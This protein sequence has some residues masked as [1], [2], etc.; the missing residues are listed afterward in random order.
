MATKRESSPLLPLQDKQRINLIEFGD[1][2]QGFDEDLRIAPK[3]Q[4]L[5]LH[6]LQEKQTEN[7]IKVG[8]ETQGFYEDGSGFH[9]DGSFISFI[10]KS[11]GPPQLIFC[12]FVYALSFGSIIGV[13]P[14]VMTDRYARLN[15]G[16]DGEDCSYYIGD[17]KPFECRQ[18]SQDAQDL[19]ATTSLISNML[20]FFSSSLLGSLG[21]T[22]GRKGILIAGVLLGMASPLALMMIQLKPRLSPAWYYY[23]GCL[24]GLVNWL[25]VAISALSDVVPPKWR[26]PCFGLML[27]GFSSG[28]AISPTLSLTM[29]HTSISIF[30]FSILVG[31][32]FFTIFVVPETLPKEVAEEARRMRIEKIN[33]E[34]MQCRN[35]FAQALLRPMKELSILNRSNLFRLLSVLAFFSSVISA[36][37]QNLL[38][39]Y[40]EDRYDFNDK[41]V[42]LLFL[43]IGG[44]G[45]AVQGFVLKPLNDRM[46]EKNLIILS[47]SVGIFVNIL[48][49]VA[50]SKKVIFLAVSGASLIGMSFPTISAIKSNNVG[51][52]EQ[53]RIQGALYS[54]SALA[55]AIGPIALRYVYY[56]TKDTVFPGPGAMFIFAAFLYFLATLFAFALPRDKTDSNI[57]EENINSNKLFSAT[58]KI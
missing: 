49:G 35:P 39:Y 45:V 22:R 56:K 4:S 51:D 9:E 11:K 3:R 23:P 53:G 48:Y 5:P 29:S 17:E 52:L 44:L 36:A 27:A 25:A 38:L 7:L 2:T 30:S 40:L 26:A 15:H 19:S 32:F 10:I 55:S 58:K 47:F 20:T 12:S 6:S 31:I 50:P 21:D 43:I 24:T 57:V 46:G 33:N 42:S 41:D 34:N 16:F 28:V 54:I 37:D 13:V 18:G 1:E 14:A 8:D